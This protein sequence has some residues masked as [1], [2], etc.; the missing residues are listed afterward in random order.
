MLEKRS[1][2]VDVNTG[3]KAYCLAVRKNGS[4]VVA[5]EEAYDAAKRQLIVDATERPDMVKGGIVKYLTKSQRIDVEESR[6][7]S[8]DVYEKAM[9]S[10]EAKSIKDEIDKLKHELSD[11]QSAAIQKQFEIRDAYKRSVDMLKVKP[12]EKAEQPEP[13]EQ[14]EPNRKRPPLVVKK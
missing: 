12:T 10:P 6:L 1:L 13:T 8:L 9:A 11:L 5:Y 3:R 2:L 7:I 4:R 14:P